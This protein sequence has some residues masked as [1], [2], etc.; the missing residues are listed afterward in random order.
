GSGTF[1]SVT[2]PAAVATDTSPAPTV[3]SS[4]PPTAVPASAA[5]I[6]SLK[7]TL[8]VPLNAGAPSSASGSRS[9]RAWTPQQPEND[10]KRSRSP[11][12]VTTG[13]RSMR[14]TLA[15]VTYLAR[16]TAAT[17]SIPAAATAGSVSRPLKNRGW[18]AG[19]ASVT[20]PSAEPFWNVECL[21]HGAP[22]GLGVLAVGERLV[23]GA[24]AERAQHLVL[25]H[26]LRVQLA[27]LLAHPVPELGELHGGQ[28]TRRPQPP[29]RTRQPR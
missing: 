28:A 24:A 27:E 1:R 4:A 14:T 18:T 13:S 12:L 17:A 3:S 29:R 15:D 8:V 5:R 25:G 19:P 11:L 2:D 21:D 9:S 10:S 6:G 7:S 26:A 22:D 20:P 23:H 16:A